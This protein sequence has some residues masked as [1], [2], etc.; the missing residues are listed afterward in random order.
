MG[1][2]ALVSEMFGGSGEQMPRMSAGVSD[3]QATSTRR[4]ER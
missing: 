2:F 1:A 3:V 4:G